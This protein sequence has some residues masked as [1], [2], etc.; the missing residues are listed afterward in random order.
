MAS[1]RL[2]I[3]AVPRGTATAQA[4]HHSG[5][6]GLIDK[7]EPVRLQA[8]ARLTLRALVLARLVHVGA[9]LLASPQPFSKL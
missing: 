6:A 4:R 1:R 7:D 8:R 2:G 3:Q 5:G 9:S